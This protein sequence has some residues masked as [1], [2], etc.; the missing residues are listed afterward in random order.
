[1]DGDSCTA[2]PHLTELAIALHHHI[3]AHHLTI[4]G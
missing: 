2:A 3:I 4:Q 1:M